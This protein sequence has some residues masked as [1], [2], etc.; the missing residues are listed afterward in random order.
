VDK[1][2]QLAV[3]LY[4][5]HLVRYIIVGGTTFVIDF[6]LLFLFKTRVHTS[7]AVATSIGYWVSIVYNFTLNRWWSFSAAEVHSLKRHAATY[8]I[9]LIFNYLFTLIFISIVSHVVYFG[10]AKAMAVIIQ[11]SWTY[12]I[13]KN[14]IFT[15]KEP[16][17]TT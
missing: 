13:Y 8:G 10:I 4:R 17:S 14:Y 7:L 12:F 9:L 15:K 11:T 3:V 2:K 16:Q 1:T 5:H 6:G